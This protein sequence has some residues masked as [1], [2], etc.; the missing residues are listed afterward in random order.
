MHP[1]DEVPAWRD[2]GERRH[3]PS[4]SESFAQGNPQLER[5]HRGAK[6]VRAVE[7]FAFHLASVEPDGLT[8]SLCQVH[9]SIVHRW[10]LWQRSSPRAATASDSSKRRG[11]VIGFLSLL[12][13]HPFIHSSKSS[14]LFVLRGY[15]TQSW[16]P[17]VRFGYTSVSAKLRCC[18]AWCRRQ[19]QKLRRQHLQSQWPEWSCTCHLEGEGSQINFVVPMI[20]LFLS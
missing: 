20:P 10:L 3:G 6:F 1:E 11:R 18:G 9:A 14:N 19:W 12:S 13:I 8:V 5:I 15:Q 16:T 7:P 2:G 17:S 4:R